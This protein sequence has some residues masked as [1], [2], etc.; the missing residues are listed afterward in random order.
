ME[1]K[2][3]TIHVLSLS[4]EH[5]VSLKNYLIG[6]I[7]STALCWA[8]WG[9]VLTRI[10]P[11]TAGFIGLFIFY[12]S[13]LFALVGTL[14]L[15]GFAARAS[16]VRTVPVFRHIGVSLRQAVLFGLLVVGS[17]FLLGNDLFTWWNALFFIAGLTL[18]ESF[19]LTRAQPRSRSHGN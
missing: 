16:F 1:P 8:S 17:L 11:E 15:I 2:I 6:M 10:D 14:S 13:L 9:L 18:I 4:E 3:S 7:L 12:L 5:A 19:F